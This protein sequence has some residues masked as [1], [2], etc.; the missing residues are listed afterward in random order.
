[1]LAFAPDTIVAPPKVLRRL[2][3]SGRLTA[4]HIFSGAEVLDPL[5]RAV[6]EAA[7][8]GTVREIYMATEGLLGVSCPLGTLH[9][10]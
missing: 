4:R 6:I 9:L 5:D 1:M 7:T 10:V 8:G 2:A 3:E